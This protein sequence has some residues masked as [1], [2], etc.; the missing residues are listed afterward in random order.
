MILGR[1]TLRLARPVAE[2]FE[3]TPEDLEV[4]NQRGQDRAAVVEA[5]DT[6]H[7]SE[8]T[9]AGSRPAD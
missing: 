8:P 7:R 4:G 5:A 6:E 2:W 3:S 1:R 9:S